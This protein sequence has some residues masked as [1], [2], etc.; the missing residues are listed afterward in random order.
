[1]IGQQIEGNTNMK[2]NRYA[3]LAAAAG[4]LGLVAAAVPLAAVEAADNPLV[5][6]ASS[7]AKVHLVDGAANT[8]Y[9]DGTQLSWDDTRGI[10]LSATPVASPPANA[11]GYEN[12]RLPA[13]G[14][15]DQA[16]TFISAPGKESS[17]SDWKAYSDLVPLNGKG[18]LLPQVTPSY[19][20]NGPG[21]GSVRTDGGRY[22][23]G[24][25]YVKNNAQTVVAAYFTTIDVTASTGAWKFAT[26]DTRSTTTTT[27]ATSATSVTVGTSVTLTATVNQ[28]A[29]TGNVTFTDGASTVGTAAVSNG[30][31]TLDVATPGKLA[32]GA[33]SLT[34]TYAGDSTYAGSTSGAVS[35]AVTASDFTS[36]PVPVISGTAKIG[37]TLSVI[38]GTWTPSATFTYQWLLNGA[39]ISGQTGGTL[40]VAPTYG[41]GTI[42]V[43]VTGSKTGYSS[44][45]RTS[46]TVS[47]PKL[48]FTKTY[49]PTVSGNAKV[50]KKLTAKVSKWSP[51]A[52]FSYQWLANGKAISGAKKSTLTLTKALK[53]KKI[54]VKV[55]GSKTGYNTVS[56]T[57]KST[58]KVAK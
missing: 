46:T 23:L 44:V 2:L 53:G 17:P 47:V 11:A 8:S 3:R 14:T 26:A 21:L 52:S 6:P 35:V 30:V 39:A 48:G 13:A 15:A 38:T 32:V 12:L 1:M 16:V 22:S 34:A 42:S 45:T 5:F 10:F 50:G 43:R 56:L 29:A 20:S 33:H 27:L 37:S 49:K 58:A 55:T 9:P 7:A 54:S 24:V 36:T 4:I 25:A 40:L 57:S 41:G 28:N 18:V 51:T 31:A 19:Q